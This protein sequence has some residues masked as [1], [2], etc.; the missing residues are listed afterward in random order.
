MKSIKKQIG[1]SGTSSYQALEKVDYKNQLKEA[2]HRFV[3]KQYITESIVAA[4]CAGTATPDFFTEDAFKENTAKDKKKRSKK[5]EKSSSVDE[6]Q[7]SSSLVLKNVH[8]EEDQTDVKAPVLKCDFYNINLQVKQESD[9]VANRRN[10]VCEEDD[11]ERL[12]L[13]VFLREYLLIQHLQDY[14]L[15]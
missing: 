11:Y 12:G 7:S 15:I 6:C 14:S 1:L 4:K 9:L 3:Q 8:A 10:A 13:N 5:Y 2:G